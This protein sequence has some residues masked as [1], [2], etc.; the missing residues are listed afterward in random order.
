MPA[1]EE[2]NMRHCSHT[3]KQDSALRNIREN[4]E[5]MKCSCGT[6]VGARAS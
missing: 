4:A 1:F 5:K 6:D 3:N 2:K